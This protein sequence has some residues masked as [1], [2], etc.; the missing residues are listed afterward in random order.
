MSI[1]AFADGCFVVMLLA[2]WACFVKVEVPRVIAAVREMR[3]TR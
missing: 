2:W 1:E 3:R